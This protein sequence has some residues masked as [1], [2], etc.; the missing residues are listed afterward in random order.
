MAGVRTLADGK[1]KLTILTTPPANLAAITA[2]ELAAGI[3]ASCAVAK[4]GT[5]FSATNSDTVADAR[6]CDESNANA[7]GS[8]NYEGAIVPFWLLDEDGSYAAADNPV[9]EAARL[10]GTEL[11][12]VLREGP[13][14]KTAWASGDRY[15]VF[16]GVS[17][18]PQRPSEGT[19][20]V[21]RT[22]PIEVQSAL[23][24]QTV[25]GA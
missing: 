13:S 9:Y 17:D 21:K 15:D 23:L 22:I 16:V 7:L 12:Y 19:G 2:T 24:D 1:T 10:K 18:N 5:R 4:S 14:A 3:D 11:T 20:Y 8:S 25:A 6:L